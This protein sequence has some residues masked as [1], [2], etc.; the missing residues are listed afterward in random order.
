VNLPSSVSEADFLRVTAAV[1]KALYRKLG[2]I[3]GSAE[4]FAQ[5][6]VVWSIQ[7]LPKYDPSR[8]LDGYLFTVAKSRAMNAIRDK[9]TRIDTVCP[10]CHAGT[11][12][13]EDGEFCRKYR[14]WVE[15]NRAK[16]NLS[17]PLNLDT[18][19]D[20]AEGR[21][22]ADSVVEALA[23]NRELTALIDR[24]LPQ[25]IRGDYL[26]MLAGVKSFTNP[27][28]KQAVREEIAAIL[29]Q[30]GVDLDDELTALAEKGMARQEERRLEDER[31]R[32]QFLEGPDDEDDE[33]EEDGAE[34]DDFGPPAPET[35]LPGGR[36]LA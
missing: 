35:V 15:R 20:E 2:A 28:R 3:H 33:Q 6:V 11:P 31:R 26:M 22:K 25:D 30:A 14:R 34:D 4:D 7:A 12:C 17:S 19:S 5:E 16:A 24:E 10:V 21:L 18:V 8:S 1:A 13:G 9:V 27:Q 32:E 29:F 36:Q 23:E